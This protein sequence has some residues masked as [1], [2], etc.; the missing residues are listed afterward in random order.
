PGMLKMKP[1]HLT[2][3]GDSP[4]TISLQSLLRIGVTIIGKMENANNND[5]F[6]QPNAAMHVKFADGFSAKVK[7]MMDEF[8][9]KN[10]LQVP[11]AETDMDDLPD[12]NA[13]CSSP[14]TS[15]NTVKDNIQTIIWTTG[16]SGNFSYIK[17]PVFDNDGNP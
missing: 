13:E 11:V 17:L 1:P 16:F 6:F 14:V 2:G 3:V 7:E 10:Q 9:L 8:I 12:I 15:L 4:K 5:L